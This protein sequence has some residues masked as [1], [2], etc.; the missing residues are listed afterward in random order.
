MMRVVLMWT[1]NDF[2]ALGVISGWSTKG[3]LACPVCMGEVKAKQLKYG[4]KPTFCG[5]ARYFLEEDDP[6]RRSIKF[7]RYDKHSSTT[8]HSGLI[9][10]T[11]CEQ[12]QFPPP[13]KTTRQNPRDYGVTHSWTHSSPFYELPYWKTLRLRHDIDVMLTEKN[14]FDNIFYTMLDDKKK[15]K[16]ILKSRYDCKELGVHRDLWIRDD[17]T[18]PVAPYVLTRD[19]IS[20]SSGFES[21][22]WICLKYISVCEY[23]KKMY[24]WDEIA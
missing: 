17:G 15:S 2:P 23:E 10:K 4:G 9:A 19:Q 12:I 3:K 6:P 22:K 5:T 11:M 21:S 8:R 20:Y 16:D 18:K 14:V 24:S 13:G 1:I 7:G